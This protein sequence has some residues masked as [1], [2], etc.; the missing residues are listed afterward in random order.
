[1]SCLT[2]FHAHDPPV[3]CNRPSQ[4]RSF[5]MTMDITQQHRQD[6]IYSYCSLHISRRR[7]K[8]RKPAGTVNSLRSSVRQNCRQVY[9]NE[10]HP[11]PPRWSEATHAHDK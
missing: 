3:S 5:D 6:S 11:L 10:I 8:V 1:M 2:R 4:L 9:T 7:Q